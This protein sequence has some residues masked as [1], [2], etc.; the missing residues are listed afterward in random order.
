MKRMSKAQARKRMLE[1]HSKLVKVY[2]GGMSYL[3]PSCNKKLNRMMEELNG[4]AKQ[5]KG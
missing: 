3:S 5:L 4:M 2:F 1:C